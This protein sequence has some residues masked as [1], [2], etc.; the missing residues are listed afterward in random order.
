MDYWNEDLGLGYTRLGNGVTEN[1]FRD[2]ITAESQH[3]ALAHL[4]SI[5]SR[6]AFDPDRNLYTFDVTR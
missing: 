4:G 3:R 5:V 1:V 6:V 2:P